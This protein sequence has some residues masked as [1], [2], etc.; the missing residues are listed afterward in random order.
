MQVS[1]PIKDKTQNIK[2]IRLYSPDWASSKKRA[3]N[4]YFSHQRNILSCLFCPVYSVL[5]ILSCLF[6]PVY[7]V[8]FI[9][10]CFPK[11][12]L[13]TKLSVNY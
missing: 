6:C 8:L 3:L 1:F 13:Y 5:F 4:I 2:I 9:L 7:S 12:N 10:S 11:M